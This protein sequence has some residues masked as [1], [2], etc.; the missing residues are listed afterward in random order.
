MSAYQ[1]TGSTSVPAGKKSNSHMEYLLQ[2]FARCMPS[3]A[4][5]KTQ[6]NICADGDNAQNTFYLISSSLGNWL[7]SV[8][9]INTSFIFSLCDNLW[10]SSACFKAGYWSK[11]VA[12]RI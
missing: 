7:I 2:L 4:Y 11:E 10:K 9:G 6:C 12:F 3:F 1:R 5:A 8:E